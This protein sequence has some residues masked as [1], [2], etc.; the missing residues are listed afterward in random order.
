MYL[1]NYADRPNRQGYLFLWHSVQI[2][3]LGFCSSKIFDILLLIILNINQVCLIYLRLRLNDNVITCRLKKLTFNQFLELAP[4]KMIT[5][6]VGVYM[7]RNTM[8]QGPVKNTCLLGGGG[9][10]MSKKISFLLKQC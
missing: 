9:G 1:E 2:F 10:Q 7:L 8:V 6:V 3:N 5:L 4:E